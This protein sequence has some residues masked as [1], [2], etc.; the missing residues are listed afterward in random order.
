MC[1]STSPYSFGVSTVRGLLRSPTSTEYQILTDLQVYTRRDRPT[2]TRG[3]CGSIHNSTCA[4]ECSATSAQWP[5]RSPPVREHGHV[6][7]VLAWMP[8]CITS[9]HGFPQ[10]SERHGRGRWYFRKQCAS[11][12]SSSWRWFW[13]IAGA[14]ATWQHISHRQR[15]WCDR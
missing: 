13:W 12:A 15:I 4:Y 1:R 11:L 8:Q 2:P 7:Q 9:I 5:S 3:G 10:L 6:S 14:S